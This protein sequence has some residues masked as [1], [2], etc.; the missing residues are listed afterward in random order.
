MERPS[1]SRSRRSRKDRQHGRPPDG[2]DRRA[3]A[4]VV[5]EIRRLDNPDDGMDREL[6]PRSTSANVSPREA[7]RPLCSEFEIR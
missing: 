2:Q 5:A 3:P 1:P 6:V 4:E 7:R